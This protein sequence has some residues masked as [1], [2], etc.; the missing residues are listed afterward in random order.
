[1][2]LLGAGFNACFAPYWAAVSKVRT[3]HLSSLRDLCPDTAF[4][5]S[6][7]ICWRSVMPTHRIQ[8]TLRMLLRWDQEFFEL[9]QK[10]WKRET[11][12]D[13]PNESRLLN[14]CG[15]ETTRLC[16]ISPSSHLLLVLTKWSGSTPR[17]RSRGCVRRASSSLKSKVPEGGGVGGS[18]TLRTKPR[19]L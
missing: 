12:Q 10:C 7:T 9:S 15:S 14:C 17:G 3:I 1:M 5:Y 19:S 11:H 16:R 4:I 8:V 13:P 2:V 6:R 18:W